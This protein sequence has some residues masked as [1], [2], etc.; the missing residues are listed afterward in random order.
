M[1]K[2]EA[3]RRSR[4]TEVLQHARALISDG[5]EQ[6]T[7]AALAKKMDASVGG[8]YRYYA[9][10]EAILTALQS[11][12]LAKLKAD[13][14][15]TVERHLRKEGFDWTLVEALF[16]SWTHFRQ[17]DP[18]SVDILNAFSTVQTPVLDNLQREQLGVDIGSVI[19]V[20]ELTLERLV[21]VECLRSGDHRIRALQLWGLIFG[22][23][24]LRLR[25]ARN[26]S[27]LPLD[28]IRKAYLND[29]KTAW[30]R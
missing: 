24:Q 26:I 22:F 15:G 4:Q 8:L 7:M 6:L 12:A 21:A 29:L 2:R 30:H 14:E 11:Q 16:D 28:K 17:R 27:T 25:Q 20:L 23:E 3:R 19:E 9:S 18:L 13:I 10:K 1:T 5:F